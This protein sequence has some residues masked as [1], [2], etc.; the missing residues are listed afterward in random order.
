MVLGTAPCMLQVLSPM[1]RR[2]MTVGGSGAEK[3][4][5]VINSQEGNPHGKPNKL[6]YFDPFSS[7]VHKRSNISSPWPGTLK[8][9][10][11]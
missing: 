8:K 2:L 5:K 7:R 11:K 4:E 3:G 6:R 9:H 1:E 10:C